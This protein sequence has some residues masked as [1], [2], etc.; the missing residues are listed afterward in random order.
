VSS[1]KFAPKPGK[2]DRFPEKDEYKI[3]LDK[4]P[5]CS[6]ARGK[7]RIRFA[8]FGLIVYAFGEKR[9]VE[10]HAIFRF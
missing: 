9:F 4:F 8:S 6:A 1:K 10:I 3:Y 5:G 2:D 7:S